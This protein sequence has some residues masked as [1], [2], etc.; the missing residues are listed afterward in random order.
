MTAKYRKIKWT[1]EDLKLVSIFD[2]TEEESPRLGVSVRK[3]CSYHIFDDMTIAFNV[4]VG[5]YTE[6]L[7]TGYIDSYYEYM[8]ITGYDIRG[9]PKDIILFS[10]YDVN[11]L[12]CQGSF[13]DKI[14]NDARKSII[15]NNWKIK[16][17]L[18]GEDAL[19]DGSDIIDLNPDYFKRELFKRAMV[20]YEA[21]G[22]KDINSAFKMA[23][24]DMY[25]DL[26]CS[27]E[28]QVLI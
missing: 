19:P 15:D 16:R 6:Q 26:I 20:K 3:L 24:S 14:A 8:Y 28:S 22:Y 4:L 11:W 2:F 7:N 18:E 5:Y 12:V 21:N 17:V 25:D 27:K 23:R 10:H 13:K 1:D 9:C